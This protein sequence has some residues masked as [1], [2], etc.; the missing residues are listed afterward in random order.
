MDESVL[1]CVKSHE[2]YDMIFEEDIHSHES[3]KQILT[4]SLYTIYHNTMKSDVK[5]QMEGLDISG[6]FTC[7]RKT[8]FQES[9]SRRPGTDSRIRV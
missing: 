4:P 7:R 2:R 3:L 1:A 5:G 9:R 6:L 8:P